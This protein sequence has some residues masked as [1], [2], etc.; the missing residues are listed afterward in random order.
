MYGS[1][2]IREGIRVKV[3]NRPNFVKW[4]LFWKVVNRRLQCFLGPP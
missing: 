3:V 1:T 2:K 4:D